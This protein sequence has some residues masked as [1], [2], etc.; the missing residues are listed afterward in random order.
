MER[1]SRF[2]IGTKTDSIFLEVLELERRAMYAPVV[3]KI[4]ILQEI[5][6]EIDSLRFFLQILWE[7]RLIPSDH[8]AS[9]GSEIE[10]I[11]RNI[12]GWKKGLVEKT[13]AWQKENLA[14][15]E[16]RKE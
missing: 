10:T 6:E 15:A 3:K 1:S 8:Y 13:S 14:K 2:G 16:E 9:L 12:G 4:T 7:L 5:I 11:G